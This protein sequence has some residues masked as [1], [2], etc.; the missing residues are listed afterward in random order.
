M[1]KASNIHKSYDKLK[2]LKGVDLEISEASITSIVGKSGTGN[3]GLS[4]RLHHKPSELSGGEQQRVA[5]A[6]ALV[7]KP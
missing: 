5:V 1:L 7:N 4:E 3:L 6:R 2:V